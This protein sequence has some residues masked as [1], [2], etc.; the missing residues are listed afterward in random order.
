[1]TMRTMPPTPATALQ[2]KQLQL[3]DR[4]L[5]THCGRCHQSIPRSNTTL[6]DQHSHP[7]L[8]SMLLTCGVSRQ[9]CDTRLC[10][11][12]GQLVAVECKCCQ[13]TDTSTQS[14]PPNQAR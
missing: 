2:C 14:K 13:D 9:H 1:M 6:P 8:V 12:P 11:A 4:L 7:N 5:T 3:A 10:W